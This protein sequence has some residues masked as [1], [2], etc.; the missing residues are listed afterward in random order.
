MKLVTLLFACS[1]LASCQTQASEHC[2]IGTWK[3]RGN[4]AAEWMAR[5]MHGMR[6]SMGTRSATLRLDADGTYASGVRLDARAALADG[7]HAATHGPISTSSKGHWKTEGDRLILEP[8]SEHAD[9]RIDVVSRSGQ[10]MSR[11]LPATGHATLRMTY[12]CRG[13][14]LV[15]RKTFAGIADPMTQPYIR[16][17]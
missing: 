11:P 1:L 3:A 4:G 5:H 17:R 15:T 13:D 6:L 9:G 7:G 14:T 10:R 16:V 12:T 2:L 8:V